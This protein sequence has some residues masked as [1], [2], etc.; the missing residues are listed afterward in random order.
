MELG[1]DYNLPKNSLL[2]IGCYILII[3]RVFQSMTSKAGK[4]TGSGR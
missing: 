2:R 4:L 1:A 3:R